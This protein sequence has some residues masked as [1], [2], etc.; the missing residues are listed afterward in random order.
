V[1]HPKNTWGTEHVVRDFEE[2]RTKYNKVQK[3]RKIIVKGVE[4]AKRVIDS[5]LPFDD[6]YKTALG[7]IKQSISEYQKIG[8]TRYPKDDL[9]WAER[10][11]YGSQEIADHRWEHRRGQNDAITSRMQDLGYWVD[12]KKRLRRIADPARRATPE[13]VVYGYENSTAP[14]DIIG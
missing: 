13:M 3:R 5:T 11:Y 10:S 12:D 9:H 4:E 2:K 1:W 6:A 14:S 7:D 8:Y